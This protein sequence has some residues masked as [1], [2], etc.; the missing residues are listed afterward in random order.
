MN[1]ENF[2]NQNE[3]VADCH[4]KLMLPHLLANESVHILMRYMIM[5][6]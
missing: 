4:I 1:N 5:T 2:N 3:L 6:L